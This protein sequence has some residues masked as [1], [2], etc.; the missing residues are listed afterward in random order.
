MY[1]IGDRIVHPMHGAGVIEDIVSRRINAAV[2]EYY[3]F[4][5]PAGRVE[6]LIPVESCNSLG[7]RPV[8]DAAHAHALLEDFGSLDV[9]PSANWNQR[10]RDNMERLRSGKLTEVARVVRCLML[11]EHNHTLSSVERRML[12]SARQILLSELSLATGYD[13]SRLDE[14]LCAALSPSTTKG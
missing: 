9:E 3:V 4:R 2:R 11:R 6:I 1:I 5:V 13:T 14:I 7:I 12:A 8:V 10:Y